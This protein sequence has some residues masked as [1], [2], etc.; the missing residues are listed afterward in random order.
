MITDFIKSRENTINDESDLFTVHEAVL[1]G[2]ECLNH[3]IDI[4]MNAYVNMSVLILE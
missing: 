2:F 3:I 1:Y 4:L